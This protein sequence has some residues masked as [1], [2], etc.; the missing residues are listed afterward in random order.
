MGLSVLGLICFYG[1]DDPMVRWIHAHNWAWTE[2]WCI[3]GL[4]QLGKAWAPIW[5]LFWWALV[6]KSYHIVRI[7]LVA[8]ILTTAFVLPLKGVVNR[9]RPKATLTSNESSGNSMR[10]SFPSGDTATVF[11]IVGVLVYT[12]TLAWTV[13]LLT[14]A[15]IVALLRIAVLAHYP[16]DVC[17]G[18]AIGLI[19]ALT[20]QKIMQRLPWDLSRLNA[21]WIVWLGLVF[22]PALW[23][24]EGW[25]P[26]CTFFSTCV[27]I[28]LLLTLIQRR[29]W[30]ISHV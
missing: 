26:V 23:L 13:G 3:L 14:V 1:L 21:P 9:V 2:S 30:K 7:A 29:C 10:H 25:Q 5:L 8:L 19:C 28:G 6:A 22:I 20:A 27:P 18:A 4:R 15:S 17:A 24:L 12:S 16:S 11:C